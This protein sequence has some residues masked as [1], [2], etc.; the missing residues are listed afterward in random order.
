MTK[1]T[2]FLCYSL[3]L[4]SPTSLVRNELDLFNPR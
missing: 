4:W 2:Q 1:G 3:D